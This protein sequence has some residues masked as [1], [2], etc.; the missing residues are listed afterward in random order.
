MFYR[1]PRL[2]KGVDVDLDEDGLWWDSSI[3]ELYGS[4]RYRSRVCLYLM[5]A[6]ACERIWIKVV[7]RIFVLSFLREAGDFF[8]YNIRK[9]NMIELK[10]I[11]VDFDGFKAVDDVS[12]KIEKQDAYGIVGFSGAGKSTL[13]RTINLLQRLYQLG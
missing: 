2:V 7:T 8:Y 13:V 6:Y 12:I 5:S 9:G 11:T 10:N 4:S 3:L 1:E